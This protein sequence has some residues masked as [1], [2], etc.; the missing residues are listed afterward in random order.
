MV[1]WPALAAGRYPGGL[2][3]KTSHP[4]PSNLAIVYID[5]QA[6][7][8]IGYGQISGKPAL[9]Y[10]EGTY[11]EGRMHL[12]YR[13]SEDALPAGWERQGSMLLELSEDGNLMTGRATSASG[14]WSGPI[15]FQRIGLPV[16]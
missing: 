4:D 6:A 13:Y 5:R 7:R 16:D 1:V 15:A 10:A 9:W 14:R 11:G 12:V 8:V 3:T 2:W